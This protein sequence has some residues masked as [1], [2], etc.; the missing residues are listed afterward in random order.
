MKLKAKIER[1]CTTGSLGASK[2]A[3]SSRLSAVGLVS[4]VR[5]YDKT[6]KGGKVDARIEEVIHQQAPEKKGHDYRKLKRDVWKCRELYLI[7]PE[8]YFLYDFSHLSDE[9]RHQ[10]VGNR[11]KELLCTKINL[12][13]KSPWIIFMNKWKAYQKFRDYYKRES[14]YIKSTKDEERF[15]IFCQKHGGAIVKDNYSSQGRGI[16]IVDPSETGIDDAWNSIKEMLSRKRTVIIE[17]LISQAPEMMQF[18]PDSVNT[19]RVATFY[20]KGTTDIM[21]AF[22][23][24]G[25]KGSVVDNGGAG[26]IIAA[27]DCSSGIVISDGRDENGIIY[28]RHPDSN[29]TIRGFQVPEWD[30]AIQLCHQLVKV[31]PKQRY[32]GWDLAYSEEGWIMVEGNSWSQ[33]V[34]PQ[35]AGRE[36]IRDV[37]NRTF[38]KV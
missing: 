8:E 6:K 12:T 4:C 17:Q 10:F 22:V 31:V 11:E 19:V 37:I 26:G 14:I 3:R 34:G 30:E 2:R 5:L 23:R 9:G 28:E 27:L 35:I 38:Y 7:D 32:V 29:L 13:Q 15:R 1:V 33:F 25:R 21:F 16:F 18:N 20:R 24:L 36:G